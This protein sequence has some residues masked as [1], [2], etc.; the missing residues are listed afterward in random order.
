MVTCTCL[1]YRSL[2]GTFLGEDV[3]VIEVAWNLYFYVGHSCD[4]SH[5]MMEWCDPAKI[6]R[7]IKI[8]FHLN[9]LIPDF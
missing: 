4:N 9:V 2:F 5:F 8:T 7:A 3:V 6:F 1:N